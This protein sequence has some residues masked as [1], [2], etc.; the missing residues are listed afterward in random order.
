MKIRKAVF[1]VTYS[2]VGKE[3]KYL[4]LKRKLHWKGWEFPKGGVNFFELKR[5]AVKRELKEETGLIP[6]KINSFHEKGFYKYNKK[7]RD[8]KGFDGQSYYLYSAQVEYSKKIKLDKIE[9]SN[10]KWMNFKEAIKKVTWE[11]Q[12]TCLKIVNDSLKK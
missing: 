12:K 3:I 11:N 6:I 1:I 2:L 10:Y 9:H 5:F 4:I 8:R 7:H